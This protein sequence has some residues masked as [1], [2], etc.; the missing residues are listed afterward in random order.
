MEK[1]KKASVR[2]TIVDAIRLVV[3]SGCGKYLLFTSIWLVMGA[4]TSFTAVFQK[5][6]INAAAEILGG[7]ANSFRVAAL[8]LGI[9]A[10]VELLMSLTN[11]AVNRVNSRL[12]QRVQFFIQNEVAKKAAKVRLSYFDNTETHRI[13]DCVKQN[14]GDRISFIIGAAFEV[15]FSVVKFL[16]VGFIIAGENPW[17]A[18]IIM[19]SAIPSVIIQNLQTEE[20]YWDEQFNSHEARFQDYMSWLLTWKKYA[21][22]MQFYNLYDYINKRFDESVKALQGVRIKTVKKYT[23]FNA[24]ASLLNYVAIGVSLILIVWDI[25]HGRVGVGSF[26][27]VYT[28]AQNLQHSVKSMFASML[29]IGNEGRYIEDYFTMMSYEEELDEKDAVA[30]KAEDI[31][32]E[33]RNVTFAYPQTERI[34]LK[35]INLEIKQGEKIAIIGENGSGKST[36]IALLTGLYQ[37]VSGQ[38]LVNGVDISKNLAVLRKSLSCT[39]QNFVQYQLTI[40]E[41]I[42]L[43]DL[44]HEHSE[45]DVMDAAKK[46]GIYDEVMAMQDGFETPLGNYAENGRDLSGGQWQKIAMARNLIKESA[47]IMILDEPTAALD[48]VAE[49]DLYRQFQSLTEDRTVLLISHRLGATRLAERV[50]V[51]QDGQIVEDGSHEELINRNGIYT[52]M[53]HA[54]SQWYV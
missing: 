5:N 52:E 43:G 3:L 36:F 40:R 6:F 38:I 45:E 33:F 35:D 31:N 22:E 39:Y 29:E 47:R 34:V 2:K 11:I 20:S 28:S 10:L 27:L 51:F 9:W 32:I 15:I 8:W 48:P 12:W 16:T 13:L 19:G 50:L 54:Q 26:I 23:G 25:Y 14:L 4:F 24:I 53:Y 30:L 49:S 46:A 17:I 37:P 1:R 41:N 7:D 44:E 18:L 21:K 42:L